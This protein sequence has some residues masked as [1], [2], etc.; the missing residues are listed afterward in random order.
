M[1]RAARHTGRQPETAVNPGFGYQPRSGKPL[2]S[3][4]STKVQQ[5][6]ARYQGLCCFS[7][8]LRC[9]C[10]ADPHLCR[11]D[12]PPSPG[13]DW[14]VLAKVNQDRPC[15]AGLPAQRRPV[16]P[17]PCQVRDQHRHRVAIR[18]R[19]H[20]AAGR[21]GAELRRAL[22]DAADAGHAYVV[23]DGTL[24]PIDRVAAQALLF[25][26]A[27][28]A[29][30]EP[31]GHR[32][33]GPG[34]RVGLRAA[35]RRCARP[36]R[37]PDRASCRPGAFGPITLAGKGYNGAIESVLTRNGARTSRSPEN[38]ANRAHARLR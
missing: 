15:S 14:L 25:R 22:R 28:Q 31:A 20:G 24:I 1:R 7:T 10:R 29:R 33:P 2:V 23:L 18:K 27:P 16:R 17:A 32:Q 36:D 9:R 4:R 13:G 8:V 21:P 11:R 30:D 34:Y 35:A 26:Q 6:P 37:R 3:E 12:H 5:G 19:D 38:R